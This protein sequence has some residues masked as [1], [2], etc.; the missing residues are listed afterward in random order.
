M[1]DLVRWVESKRPDRPSAYT[2]A[3]AWVAGVGAGLAALSALLYWLMYYLPFRSHLCH[4][5]YYDDNTSAHICHRFMSNQMATWY[6]VILGLALLCLLMVGLTE[7][8]RNI[9]R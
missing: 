8:L 9:R 3:G 1:N 7:G 6:D 5:D 2:R 4:T